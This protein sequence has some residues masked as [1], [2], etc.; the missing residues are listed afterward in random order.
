MITRQSR[1]T[2]LAVVAGL[3]ILA[4]C[5]EKTTQPS[6]PAPTGPGATPP[7]GQPP[8]ERRTPATAQP[9]A[10]G[11]APSQPPPTAEGFT[12]QPELKDVFFEPGRADIG[13]NGARVMRQNVHW[14]LANPGFLVLIEGFSDSRGSHEANLAVGERRAK[15]AMNFLVKEGIPERRITI[16]SYGSERPVC[17][18]KTETCSAKNRRVHFLA[19]PK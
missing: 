3:V 6:P 10:P 8:P 12:E 17:R 19:L 13:R 7:A 1:V 16:V 18:E 11:P 2:V 9:T 14:L 4:G 5:A 15:A